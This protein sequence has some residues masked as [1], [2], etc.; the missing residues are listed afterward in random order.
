MSEAMITASPATISPV[1][2]V[3]NQRPPLEPID[4]FASDAAL[5]ESVAQFDAGWAERRRELWLR[6]RDPARR[7]RAPGGA[8]RAPSSH[9]RSLRA[10]RKDARALRPSDV[11]SLPLRG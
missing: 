1:R 2:Q 5:A 11:R 9:Q 7:A 10:N 4:L 8:K 6:L 3:L